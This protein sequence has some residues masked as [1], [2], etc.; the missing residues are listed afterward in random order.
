MRCP[1]CERTIDPRRDEGEAIRP[2][3]RWPLTHASCFAR[4]DDEDEASHRENTHAAWTLG[5]AQETRQ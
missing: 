3:P 2:G 5:P 1:I 4:L